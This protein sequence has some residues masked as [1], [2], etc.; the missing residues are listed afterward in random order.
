MN[1][2]ALIAMSGGVDSAV[3]ALLA[4]QQGFD[5]IGITMRL[6]DNEDIGVTNQKTCC[7]LEDAAMAEQVANRLNMP[8]YVLN[9]ATEFNKLVINRFVAEYQ[10][11]ATPNPC[12]DCNRYIKFR[13]LFDK[14]TALGINYVV[15]GHYAIITKDPTTDRFL[16][17]KGAD[18]AKD[19][20]YFLYAMTQN[21]LKHTLFPLG[22]FTKEQT[23]QLAAE[24]GFSNAQK[25]D[26]QDIC[27]VPNGDYAAF[28][29]QYTNQPPTTGNFIDNQNNVL[30]KHNG[31]IKYT[32]GQRKGLGIA[33]GKPMYVTAKNPQN[34]TVTL[35]DESQLFTNT[36]HAEDFNW[37]I[38]PPKIPIIVQA[39]TRYTQ[40]AQPATAQIISDKTVKVEFA[41]PL[42]AIAKGQAVV[43]Y[44]GDI[45]VGGG[46]IV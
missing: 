27:F 42:R 34:N 24:N 12:I 11:G 37:I 39:K 40:Q 28:I 15:T 25:P 2:K 6:F 35:A 3:A 16:L 5:C 20:S 1:K 21:Q 23:R 7:S 44:D 8:F 31:H 22:N 41:Q 32:I 10:R 38:A 29:T 45:V 43:L 13:C 36:L 30:G 19:Q 26:S 14:A 18:T 9:M 4:Q 46:T 33:F 17:K